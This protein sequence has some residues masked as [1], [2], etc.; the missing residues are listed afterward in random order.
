MEN[1]H[2]WVFTYNSLEKLWYCTQRENYQDLFNNIKSDKIFNSSKIETL[3]EGIIK[4]KFG[5]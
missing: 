5:N 2:G 3:V 1:L 4:N